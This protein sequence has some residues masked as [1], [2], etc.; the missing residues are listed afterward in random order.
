MMMIDEYTVMHL[1]GYTSWD[2]GHMKQTLEDK[3]TDIE[4]MLYLFREMNEMW[5]GHDEIICYLE[6]RIVGEEE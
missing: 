2:I 6:E 5:G 4:T 1:L 3:A